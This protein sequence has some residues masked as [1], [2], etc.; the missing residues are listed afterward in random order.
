MAR[1]YYLCTTANYPGIDFSSTYAM[2]CDGV[3]ETAY[4]YLRRNN[5]DTKFWIKTDDSCA[6]PP[7]LHADDQTPFTLAE[8]TTECLNAEWQE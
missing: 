8:A 6:M 3:I 1:I 7:L 5:D 2:S 4:C